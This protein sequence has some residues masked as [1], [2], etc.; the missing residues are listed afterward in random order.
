MTSGPCQEVET[1]RGAWNALWHIPVL[2][3]GRAQRCPEEGARVGAPIAPAPPFCAPVCGS[4]LPARSLFRVSHL[5]SAISGMRETWPPDRPALRLGRLC[6]FPSFRFLI[7]ETRP[8]GFAETTW[9]C[10]AQGAHP[11]PSTVKTGPPITECALN[12]SPDAQEGD[13]TVTAASGPCLG[14]RLL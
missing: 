3:A 6:S 10:L 4:A 1:P 12:D 2:P 14:T 7:C 13:F 9:P 8:L 5:I 11:P